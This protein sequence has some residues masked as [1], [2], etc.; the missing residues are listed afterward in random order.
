[1]LWKTD[2]IYDDKQL[3]ELKYFDEFYL[4]QLYIRVIE[5]YHTENS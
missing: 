5:T 3:V 1:M 2:F 4:G